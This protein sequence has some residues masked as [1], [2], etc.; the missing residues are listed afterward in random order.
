MSENYLYQYSIKIK[1][2]VQGVFF[3]KYSQEKATQLGIKGWVSN[4][5]SGDVNMSIQGTESQCLTMIKWCHKGSPFSH[6]SQV[7][8][9]KEKLT[10]FYDSFE[11]KE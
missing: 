3:R 6:V 8:P 7:I 1:G 11:I 5:S 4:E 10:S 9:K 2:N